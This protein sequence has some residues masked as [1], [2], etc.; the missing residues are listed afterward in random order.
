[1][2]FG[3]IGKVLAG[4]AIEATKKNVLD[5][6][7][8]PETARA[9]EKIQAERPAAPAPADNIGAIV[10]GQIQGMQRALKED[11]ELVVLF[12]SG[13]ETLRVLEIFVPSVHVFVLAGVDAAQN[14]TRVVV[15]ADSAALFCKVM[16][17]APD[18]KPIKVNVL[19]PRPR[20]E[21]A[22]A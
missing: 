19:T 22:P 14:V 15:P 2:G 7:R 16:K 17:V 3:N 4:Q 8:A 1:M 18:T 12:R 13:D 21:Q 5:A 10:L 9:A 11:Q 6:L 20:T